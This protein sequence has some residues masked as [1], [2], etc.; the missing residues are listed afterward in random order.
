MQRRLL[1]ILDLGQCNSQHIVHACVFS[2][3]SRTASHRIRPF[4]ENNLD[5]VF[6]SVR[7][8]LFYEFFSLFR[9]LFSFL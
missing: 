5:T 1:K 4:F 3:M 8:I 2:G 9:A 6:H 7:L